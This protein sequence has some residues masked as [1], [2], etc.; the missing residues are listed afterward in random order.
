M[1]EENKA[2]ELET[3]DLQ[4][5]SAGEG[6]TYKYVFT[7]KDWVFE[8]NLRTYVIFVLENVSTNDDLKKIRCE[9]K[10]KG[11]RRFDDGSIEYYVYAET[12]VKCY[13]NHGGKLN[14]M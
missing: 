11:D 13:K 7:D 5:V 10:K 2:V 14:A 4:K 6:G 8:S 12:L 9:K 1:A 3:K